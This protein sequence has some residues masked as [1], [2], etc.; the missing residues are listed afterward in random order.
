MWLA[1]RDQFQ[2]DFYLCPEA[3][4]GHKLPDQLHVVQ[5]KL[6]GRAL[7]TEAFQKFCDRWIGDPRDVFGASSRSV[8]SI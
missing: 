7:Q 5:T 8:A 3:A 4:M 1:E 2:V 6:A